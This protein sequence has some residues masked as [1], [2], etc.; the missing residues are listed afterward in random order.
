LVLKEQRNFL[1][2]NMQTC[3]HILVPVPTSL[4]IAHSPNP[5]TQ[6]WQ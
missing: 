1:M 6:F 3:N 5:V 4:F 2:Q